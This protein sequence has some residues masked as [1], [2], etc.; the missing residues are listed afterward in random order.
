VSEIFII[1]IEPP[2]D[3]HGFVLLP[4]MP[5]GSVKSKSCNM[6]NGGCKPD[7]H[8]AYWPKPARKKRQSRERTSIYGEGLP[9]FSKDPYDKLRSAPFSISNLICR[10]WHDA[11]HNLQSPPS[12]LP[13]TDIV[14]LALGQYQY[15]INLAGR[16]AQLSALTQQKP[17]PG[18]QGCPLW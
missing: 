4:V 3:E 8:H 7:R 17:V 10:G 6:C 11:L 5:E 15:I 2:Q 18:T 9:D 12:H 16:V 13:D 1:P 14:Q